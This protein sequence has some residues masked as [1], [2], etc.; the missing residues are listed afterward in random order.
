VL[1]REPDLVVVGEASDLE[2]AIRQ[3]AMHRP[4]VLV[5]DLRMPDGFSAERIR[6]LLT[7]WPGTAIVVT[8]MHE[9]WM[10]ATQ[11]HRAGAIGF[12]LADAAD[13][14]L[15]EAVRCAAGGVLY[16]SPRVRNAAA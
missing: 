7:L 6:R 10:F 5:L 1:Q 14:E 12:V 8:T 9:D 16:T 11:S 13:V 15:P 2:A 4:R 3:V